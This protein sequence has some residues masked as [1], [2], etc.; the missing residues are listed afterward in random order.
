MKSELTQIREGNRKV[1]HWRIVTGILVLLLV[2]AVL[3]RM[4]SE[5]KLEEVERLA[6]MHP[7]TSSGRPFDGLRANGETAKP[8]APLQ[9]QA[10]AGCRAGGVL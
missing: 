9:R 7:S 6:Q 1:H 3:G 10:L 5:A 4:D 2:Q 8:P